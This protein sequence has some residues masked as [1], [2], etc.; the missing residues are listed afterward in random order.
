MYV[1]C[2]PPPPPKKCV[3]IAFNFCWEIQSS[4]DKF[5]TMFMQNFGGQTKCVM[6]GD[7]KVV[8][9]FISWLILHL[10]Q[11]ASGLLPRYDK[12]NYLALQVSL[13]GTQALFFMATAKA[14]ISFGT[15]P[16]GTAVFQCSCIRSLRCRTISGYLWL[17][18][19]RS[20]GSA[21]ML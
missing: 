13:H 3:S 20:V 5:N 7:V 9:S 8:N 19:C 1:V 11:K 14:I 4:Q 10:K 2:P 6:P 16:G 15:I 18:S 21:V 12:Y 17:R